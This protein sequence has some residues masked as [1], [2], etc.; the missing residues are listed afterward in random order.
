MHDITNNPNPT[1]TDPAALL[2]AFQASLAHTAR[3]GRDLLLAR[4]GPP[5]RTF[6]FAL[7][8]NTSADEHFFLPKDAEIDCNLV[9]LARACHTLIPLDKIIGDDALPIVP[10]LPDVRHPDGEQDGPQANAGAIA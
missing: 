5:P 1:P 6:G 3:L 10:H 9:L 7:F 8:T 4:A 2:V